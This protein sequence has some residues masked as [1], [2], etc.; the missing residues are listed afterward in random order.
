MP[1]E[2]R[3]RGREGRWREKR[4][5]VRVSGVHVRKRRKGRG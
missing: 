4:E 2:E 5:C 3:E 1:R